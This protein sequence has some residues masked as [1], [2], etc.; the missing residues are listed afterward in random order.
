[1]SGK[2]VLHLKTL[3]FPYDY[4]FAT[5]SHQMFLIFPYLQLSLLSAGTLRFSQVT[6][7]TSLGYAFLLVQRK[8]KS[9]TGK[10]TAY[11]ISSLAI[12]KPLCLVHRV[13]LPKITHNC[14]PDLGNNTYFKANA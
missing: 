14:Q 5:N 6:C 13:L 3:L 11:G 8:A 7:G 12:F 1:L 10:T 9:K 2:N 4:D